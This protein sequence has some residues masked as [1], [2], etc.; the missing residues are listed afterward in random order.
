MQT[1][2]SNDQIQSDL[3]IQD[4]IA[5]ISER[6][7]VA[8]ERLSSNHARLLKALKKI[9]ATH[10]LVS[11]CGSGDSGQIDQVQIF[12]N[13]EELKPKQNVRVL[14]ASGFF[15]SEQSRWI[16]QVKLKTMSLELALE[17]LVYDW[18]EAE[19][20]GWENNDGASGE[21]T[22]E[23]TKGEFLLTHTTYYTESETTES[24]L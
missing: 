24:S 16:E 15:N 10:V 8:R 9:K 17:Q 5:S 20:A 14:V 21:C 3:G 18:L 19:Y 4:I 23:I 11:Y 2:K 22:I 12:R 6:R 7:N 13:N 1:E